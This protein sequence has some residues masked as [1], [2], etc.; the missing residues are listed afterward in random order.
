MGQKQLKRLQDITKIV[1]MV[2]RR[3]SVSENEPVMKP[4]GKGDNGVAC[5]KKCYFIRFCPDGSDAREKESAL[6]AIAE[7]RRNWAL[8]D[9][10]KI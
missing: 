6:N 2:P 4:P 7:V 5:F 8:L 1:A 9:F 3:K 10:L